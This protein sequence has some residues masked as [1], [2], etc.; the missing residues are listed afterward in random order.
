MEYI[1]GNRKS[2]QLD[3][4]DRPSPWTIQ[5]LLRLLRDEHLQERP[6]LFMQGDTV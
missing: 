2:I 1:F 4:A 5:D 6:E 3:L